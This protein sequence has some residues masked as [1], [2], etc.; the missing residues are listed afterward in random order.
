MNTQ[1]IT[2]AH[3][4]SQA[5]LPKFTGSTLVTLHDWLILQPQWMVCRTLKLSG[6]LA[7]LDCNS[8][9]RLTMHSRNTHPPHALD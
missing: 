7:R 8:I 6:P 3:S 2:A 1:H 9:R 5:E 4:L